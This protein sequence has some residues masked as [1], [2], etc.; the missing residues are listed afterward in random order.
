M[1]FFMK[2][3]NQIVILF[4]SIILF[5]LLLLGHHYL[6]LTTFD[7]DYFIIHLGLDYFKSPIGNYILLFI[8]FF[9]FFGILDFLYD[10]LLIEKYSMFLYIL[11]SIVMNLILYFIMYLN[12]G[13]LSQMD[14]KSVLSLFTI[15][16]FCVIFNLYSFYYLHYISKK[17]KKNQSLPEPLTSIFD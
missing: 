11:L 6:N 16:S 13:K 8:Y 2:I 7:L 17:K 3:I 5:F 4:V 12:Y 1:I 10:R 15:I 14:V 9:L